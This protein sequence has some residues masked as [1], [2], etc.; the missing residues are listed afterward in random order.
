MYTDKFSFDNFLQLQKRRIN[1]IR[2]KMNGITILQ[3][4]L[5][6]LLVLLVLRI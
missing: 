2:D 6:V 3:R 5:P 1:N 4:V